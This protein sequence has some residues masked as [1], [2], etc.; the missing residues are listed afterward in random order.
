MYEDEKANLWICTGSG[1]VL[2][3]RNTDTFKNITSTK[4]FTVT[5]VCSYNN[6]IWVAHY[7][8]LIIFN[9]EKNTL[10]QLSLK[11]KGDINLLAKGVLHIFKDSKNRIWIGT[12]TGLYSYN[13]KKQELEKFFHNSNPES[14]ASDYINQIAEDLFG[15][16]WFATDG[17]LSMWVRNTKKF[18]NYKNNPKNINSLSNNIVY[19]LASASDGKLWVGTEDGLN[20][21]NPITKKVERVAKNSRNKYGLVGKSVKEIFLDNQ[22]IFWIATFRGGINKYDKNLAFFNLRQS[23]YFDVYGLSAPVVTSFA[24]HTKNSIFIGTDGGGLNLYQADNGSFKH[25]TVAD[26]PSEDKNLSILAMEND[27]DNLWIGTYLNG[28][29][30][31]NTKTGKLKQIKEGNNSQSLSN[32]NIFCLKRDSKGNIWIGTNGQG[33]DCY[34]LQKNEFVNYSSKKVGKYKLP[35]NGFIRAL[36]EDKEGNIW[37]G[38]NGSGIAVYNPITGKSKLISKTNTKLPNDNIYSIYVAVDGKV[39]IASAGGGLTHYDIETGNMTSFSEEQGLANGVVY[40]IIEDSY[41]KIWLSTNKGISSFDTFTKKFKN[42]SYN[43]GVQ[44]SPFVIGAGLKLDDGRIFFGGT[45]GFN[46]FNPKLISSNKNQQKV[47][48]TDLKINNLSVRP[49]EDSPIQN[50]ISVANEINLD[51]KQNFLLSFVALNYSSPQENRYS[52]KLEKFDKEWNY[53]GQSQTAIYTNLDPGTY[54]FKVKASSDAGDWTTPITEIKIV[55]NPPFWRTIYA[56]ILYL[57]IVVS[58]LFYI[59]HRGIQKLKSK[60][61]LEQERIQIQ[62][63]IEQE[64][65]ESERI[66]EFDEMKIKFLTN[67]SHEFRTPIS[68]IIGPIAQLIQ[69]ETNSPKYQQLNMVMRNARRLLNLVNQ[70]LDFRNISSNENKLNTTEGDFISF[71]KEVAESFKD[72]AEQKGINF[73]F[74]SEISSYYT[75]FDHNKIERIF[76]NLLSN[77]FKFTLEGGEIIFKIENAKRKEGLKITIIDTGIGIDEN[78]KEKIFERFFQNESNPAILN[79]GSGIGL[80]IAKEFV[81]MHGGAIEVESIKGEGSTFIIYFPFEK[82][83]NIESAKYK[84][85]TNQDIKLT[86]EETELEII[87]EKALKNEVKPSVLIV[88]DNEDFRHY[89]KENL[90]EQYT[91]IEAEN[92]KDGWQK[93]L[94]S[95]PQLVVSDINMPQVT[96]IEFCR[97]IKLDKRTKHIPVILLTA[98]T[99]EESQMLGL[100]TGAN[101]YLNKPFNFEILQFKIRNLLTMKEHL[102][103]TYSKQMNVTVKEIEVESENEKLMNKVL[104]FIESNLTNPKLSV[105]ELSSYIGMSRGS[106]Y[107]KILEMTGETPVEFIRSIKLKKAANLLEKS[108]L[109]VAQICYAVGFSTPNYF[110]RAFKT[111]YNMLPSEFINLKRN[112]GNS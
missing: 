89:L 82:I 25:I 51:F 27:G 18:I 10:T 9:K 62:S 43:N 99:G 80:S 19:T 66:H 107:T 24:K 39:W 15:N 49:G 78:A 98:I 58:V 104:H 61:A 109:N 72:L 3:D 12:N 100:E 7:S 88:D 35:V 20:I 47:I 65:L 55:V 96:G 23:N 84:L 14:I 59:R 50:H 63:L 60:F 36:A 64:R 69:Q 74:Q 110:A 16:I 45:D 28:I 112:K 29:Y 33:V 81:K 34:N 21:V 57:F 22:G 68:L 32:N 38:T 30:I 93:V 105:E 6:N 26:N 76:F 71:C 53:I 92:G 97:K 8:G 108:D 2:Y 46:Y 48:L 42:Y 67:I 111:K 1:L 106:L 77:A 56:F 75:T 102:K 94:S 44:R 91:I 31:L 54:I 87:V 90:K 17:G 52:Y 11:N 83:K 41:G 4:D 40:K 79:Q 86:N 5:S 70:L 103:N 101:D 85:D 95:H 73:D 37:I 13:S